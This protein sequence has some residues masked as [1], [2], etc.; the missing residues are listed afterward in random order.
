MG[1]TPQL[2]W[3]I[4]LRLTVMRYAPPSRRAHSREEPMR[5]V[6]TPGPRDSHASM[7]ERMRAMPP[8]SMMM[9]SRRA[10]VVMPKTV[11]VAGRATK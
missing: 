4:W 1:K 9:S 10:L 3:F 2:D 8:A 5:R 6:Q 11:P 7:A